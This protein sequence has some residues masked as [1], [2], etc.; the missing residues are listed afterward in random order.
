MELQKRVFSTFRSLAHTPTVTHSID[1]Q[2][3]PPINQPPYR[4]GPHQQELIKTNIDAMLKHKVIRPSNSPWASPVV[5]VN[6][7]DGGIRFC[8][9]YKKLNAITRK[10]SYPLPRIDDTLD[11]LFG[12]KY[13]ST[14]DLASGYWQVELTEKDKEKTA[15]ITREGLFEFNV[16]P[17]GLTNALATFQRLMDLVLAG[18]KWHNCLVYL[19]DIIIFSVT[20]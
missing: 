1:T 9:D 4:E 18:L 12:M 10:D 17:F 2:G 14:L 19:D 11:A 16:M 7:L 6:K 3:H 13:F 20:F 5:L 8:V 15:F